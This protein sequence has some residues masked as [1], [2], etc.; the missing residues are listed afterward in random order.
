MLPLIFGPNITGRVTMASNNV[1]RFESAATAF[2]LNNNVTTGGWA[3]GASGGSSREFNFNASKSNSL[4]GKSST[5][6]PSS[7]QVLIIIKS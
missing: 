5:I 3:A 1:N 6:Q 2:S 7:Y 4:F